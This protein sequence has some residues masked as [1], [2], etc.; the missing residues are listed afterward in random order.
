MK[1]T[2]LSIFT[3][4]LLLSCKNE[5]EN[6]NSSIFN[7]KE[8]NMFEE[9]LKN[10][11]LAGNSGEYSY[12]YSTNDLDITL[13]ILKNQLSTNNY[14]FPTKEDFVNKIYLIF[15]R[16]FDIISD[17]KFLYLNYLDKCN[18][19]LLFSLNDRV[20]YDG[21][22]VIKN[23]FFITDLYAI[24]L[25]VD[26][27]KEYPKISIIEDQPLKVMDNIEEADVEIG[28]WKDTDKLPEIRQKNIQII[29]NRNKYLFND[30]KASFAWLKVNDA[31]FLEMLVKT[32]GYVEDKELTKFIL[33]KNLKDNEEFGKVI[34]NKTCDGKLHFND[35]VVT[36]IEVAPSKYTETV[37]N[38][39]GFLLNKD[40]ELEFSI[41]AEIMGKL[42]YYTTKAVDPESNDYFKFFTFVGGED[43]QEEFKKT[44]YYNI[45]DF[46]S[47][48]EETKTGGVAYPGME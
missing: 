31:E 22:F 1:K 27:Q 38:Y 30:D 43:F 23:D 35:E 13:P 20:N 37:E 16:K 39:L 15:Q 26:Y 4:L 3:L 8:K 11:L 18:K 2:I 42:A 41:K 32:F 40:T 24:P 48:Y 47:I 17:S 19:D 34:W 21:T 12:D 29:I 36:L 28:K 5:K 44:N 9:I 45:K 14:K 33:D 25:I 7:N 46:Q 6:L 10:Q